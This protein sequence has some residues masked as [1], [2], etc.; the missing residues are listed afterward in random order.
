M[1]L[2]TRRFELTEQLGVSVSW[3]DIFEALDVLVIGSILC[4][5]SWVIVDPCYMVVNNPV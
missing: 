1:A 2:L 4:T 3:H 5:K